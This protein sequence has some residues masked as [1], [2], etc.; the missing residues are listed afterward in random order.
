VPL[1]VHHYYPFGSYNIGDHLVARAIRQKFVEHF[2]PAQFVDMPVGDRY[3]RGDRPLGLQGLNLD[4]TNSKADLVIVG[5]SNLLEARKP[6]RGLRPNEAPTWGVFTTLE[7]IRRLRPPLLLVG[8]GTGSSFGKQIRPYIPQAREQIRALF[9]RAFASAV[10]DATTAERLAEIGVKTQC[11]GC[12]VTFLTDRDVTAAR[13][14][15][16]LIVSFPPSRIVKRFLGKSFMR[17]AMR[18]LAW[19]RAQ[20]VPVVVTL[21]EAPDQEI[22]H[23]WVPRGTDVFYTESV[24]ELIARYEASRG[25]IGFRLHAALL[26]LGLG[27]PVV[28]VGVDW[29]GLAFIQTFGLDDIAIRPFRLGQFSKLRQLTARLLESDPGLIVRLDRA[30]SQMYRRYQG[31]FRQA[32]SSLMPLARAG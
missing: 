32:A 11:V 18:Y 23:Q 15:L 26:G 6:A 8:M 16:P 22:V 31:F 14:D 28:P 20:G 13:Q 3:R 24:D 19:L 2:G 4:Y 21:H 25:V 29:R 7:S 10:R 17:G 30:K 9:G 12:P 5:G 1:T 27:K